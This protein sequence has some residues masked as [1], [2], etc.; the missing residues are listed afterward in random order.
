MDA[1]VRQLKQLMESYG[2]D[3]KLTL[4]AYNAGPGAVARSAGV[5]RFA[6]TRLY[7]KRITQL[8]YG[9]SDSGTHYVGR[10]RCMNRFMCNGIPGAYSTSATPTDVAR[11]LEA[12]GN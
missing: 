2:G 3:V 10:V 5:P 8:Y 1:G 4:A 11:I 7:V 6:E 12:T 9:G